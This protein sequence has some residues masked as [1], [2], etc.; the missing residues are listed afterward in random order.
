M[1]RKKG[2]PGRRVRHQVQTHII[3]VGVDVRIYSQEKK[4]TGKV[5]SGTVPGT[6]WVFAM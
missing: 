4:P 2:R 5:E 3:V 1:G 6:K